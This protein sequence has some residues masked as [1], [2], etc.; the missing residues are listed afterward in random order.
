MPLMFIFYMKIVHRNRIILLPHFIRRF[1]WTL[2]IY[3]KKQKI[4]I[5]IFLIMSISS[6]PWLCLT[7]L[8]LVSATSVKLNLLKILLWMLVLRFLISIQLSKMLRSLLEILI[9]ISILNYLPWLLFK[10]DPR[11]IRFLTILNLIKL[12]ILFLLLKTKSNPT[13]F[14]LLMKP[15]IIWLF[16]KGIK[17]MI[18]KLFPL[19]P[20]ITMFIRVKPLLNLSIF[21]AWSEEKQRRTGR[22]IFL[23]DKKGFLLLKGLNLSIPEKRLVIGRA[24]WLLALEIVKMVLILLC[25]KEKL[26]FTIWSLFLPNLLKKYICKSTSFT[27]FTV[28]AL[29]IFSNPSLL[30]TVVNFLDGRI[31]K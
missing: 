7:L 5:S 3:H 18:W 26:D 11:I 22:H 6:I 2:L 13:S 17:L 9:S 24:I 14:L 15:S 27:S 4:N 25:W 29:K 8:I 21:L 31:W 20:F 12:L 23:K 10:K 1:L 30:I 28:I 16:I 19:K